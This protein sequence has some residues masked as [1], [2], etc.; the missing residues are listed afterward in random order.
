[1]LGMLAV[2]A[3]L[4]MGEAQAKTLKAF[5]IFYECQGCPE[6][7]AIPPGEFQMGS[8]P[9]EG[10]RERPRGGS[11]DE[12]PRH[13]AKIGT[14]FA[15][16]RYEVTR[17]QFA[18]F[19]DATGYRATSGCQIYFNF[20]WQFDEARSWRDPGFP[21]REQTANEPVVCVSRDDAAAYAEWL[22]RVT[23]A[24]YRLPSESEWEYAARAGTTTARFWGEGAQETCTY[25]NIESRTSL[26]HFSCKDGQ[27]YTAPVGSFRPNP[28]GLYD[29][30]GNVREWVQ[31]CYAGSYDGGPDTQAARTAPDCA[32][33][34]VRGGAWD[35][36][37]PGG[38]RSAQ[39]LDVE[40]G[41]TGN[42]LGFRVARSF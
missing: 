16:G 39:R 23:G 19:V 7:V 38:V 1:M 33:G 8:T 32:K 29:T 40:H 37:T 31:D 26:S 13:T 25:E 21:E 34:V 28:W 27:K 14:W 11:E 4:S 2:A 15:I 20:S 22:S 24:R 3:G 35:A 12:R 17:A 42:T 41:A 9:E 30:L 6:M 36:A 10:E 5:D 18:A